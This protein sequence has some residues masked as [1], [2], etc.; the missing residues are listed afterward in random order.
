MSRKLR[1]ATHLKY[2]SL[3][4]ISSQHT[5]FAQLQH[6]TYRPSSSPYR[7]IRATRTCPHTF[8]LSR[9]N[10]STLERRRLENPTPPPNTYIYI[11]QKSFSL[12]LSLSHHAVANSQQ[13]VELELGPVA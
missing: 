12:S 9:E 4:S 11:I 7:S 8:K 3:E 5:G 10:F 1:A 2:F 6:R 13:S